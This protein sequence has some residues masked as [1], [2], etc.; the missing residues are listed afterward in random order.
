MVTTHVGSSIR[1]VDPGSWDALVGE[2]TP[3]LEHAFLAALE[4]SGS[5]GGRTGWE[6]VV[7]T[8]RHGGALVGALVAWRKHHSLGEF[9]Y[10][11]GIADWAMRQG[12]PWYPKL[13]AAV[14]FS[15][16]TGARLLVLPGLVEDARAEGAPD[17]APLGF[18]PQKGLLTPGTPESRPVAGAPRA[19]RRP[20]SSGSP[21]LSG[22]LLGGLPPQCTP[23][24]VRRALLDALTRVGARDASC[25]VL[26]PGE[27]DARF[28]REAGWAERLQTQ[29]HWS[30]HGFRTFEDFLS[31]LPSKRRNSIR[32]ERREAQR[33]VEVRVVDGSLPGLAGHLADFYGSTA[34]RYTG[35]RG[36]VTPAFFEILCARWAHRVHAVVALDAGQVM[37]GTFNVQKGDRLYGRW[38]GCHEERPFLHF[39]V[40]L[41]RAIEECIT[42]GWKV[43]EPGHGGEHKRA[44]GFVPTLVTSF[45]RHRHP[46]ADAALRAYYGREAEAV[47]ARL[48]DEGESETS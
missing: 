41:Y 23:T 32:R 17:L 12:V 40:A 20:T 24:E 43:F 4:E 10:D 21:P 19:R 16:V 42:H 36:Y 11:W 35:G 45:H 1:E 34:E 29:Y 33:S 25:N 5:V 30:N 44:R 26:F 6:P 15:P 31:T 7:I 28:L 37:A 9:V 13:V 47:R 3:F 2:E 39:E 8:A 18:V 27:A 38:W 46:G 14:P 22:A 48:H